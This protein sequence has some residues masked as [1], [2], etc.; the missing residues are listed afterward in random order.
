V[1]GLRIALLQ[2]SSLVMKPKRSLYHRS[3]L[4]AQSHP[5]WTRVTAGDRWRLLSAQTQRVGGGV[6]GVRRT[7][8]FG[9][10]AAGQPGTRG[11]SRVRSVSG[12]VSRN[13]QR[14][15]GHKHGM[16]ARSGD[17]WHASYG[18]NKGYA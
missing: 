17:M 5:A 4:R 13:V 15:V 11:P 9:T 2:I 10:V 12:R 14:R 18:W 7:R 16:W 8:G 1:G 6:R 3:P